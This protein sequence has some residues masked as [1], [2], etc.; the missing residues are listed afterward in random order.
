MWV[1]R[2]GEYDDKSHPVVIYDFQDTRKTDH[3]EQFLKDYSGVL[4]TDGYQ[5]Y[6]SLEKKWND[7]QVVGCRIH[8][9]RSF[10]EY[11]KA[12]GVGE[13]YHAQSFCRKQ[14]LQEPSVLHQSGKFPARLSFQWTIMSRN[15]ASVHLHSV[16]RTGSTWTPYVA[17]RQVSFYTAWSRQRKLIIFGYMNIWNTCS[18]Y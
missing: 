15:V 11:V 2:S 10:A 13:R 14:H 6:H 1:Y 18:I 12:T 8:I 17:L 5:V 4:V 7:L 3:P 9:K 16:G